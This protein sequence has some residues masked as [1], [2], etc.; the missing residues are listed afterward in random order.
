MP[1]ATQ[2]RSLYLGAD[3]G[4]TPVEVPDGVIRTRGIIGVQPGQEYFVK[5]SVTASGDGKSW[6]TAFKTMAEALAVVESMSDIYVLGVVTEQVTAPLGVYGV[7]IIG[8]ANGRPRHG[9]SGGVAVPG[10]GAE[11]TTEAVPTNAALL[12]LREQG[13]EVHN[14]L[15]VPESGCGAIKLHREETATYPDASHFIMR[16]C[17]V[18][19]GGAQ[20]GL[21]IDDS[22]ASY[23]I[24]VSFSE[25]V[26]LEYAYHASG[27]GIAA[28]SAHLWADNLFYSNKHDIV[29]NYATSRF[30]RNV[31]ATKYDVATHIDTLNLAPTADAGV[32]AASNVVMDNVFADIAAD[33]TIANG[34]NPATGDIWRNFVTNTAAYIVAVPA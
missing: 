16:G 3:A 21:G 24:E 27:V 29:G 28:P 34:Y 19:G 20:V 14:I 15:F 17:K 31:F 22:G 25:F 2:Y 7:R 33:V 26:N 32:A 10:N 23:H 18:I 5:T 30:L 9:T 11:W 6:D 1:E 8:C 4:N 13:W 12:E